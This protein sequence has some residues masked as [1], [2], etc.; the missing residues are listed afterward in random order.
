M[1]DGTV[2]LVIGLVLRVGYRAV[3]LPDLIHEYVEGRPV[4]LVQGATAHAHT[5]GRVKDRTRREL[6]VVD[7]V[8]DAQVDDIPGL[9]VGGPLLVRREGYLVGFV[10]EKQLVPPFTAFLA[11]ASTAM[12]VTQLD[13]VPTLSAVAQEAVRV[14]LPRLSEPRENLG[15][16][17]ASRDRPPC[18]VVHDRWLVDCCDGGETQGIAVKTLSAPAITVRPTHVAVARIFVVC[19]RHG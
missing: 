2:E 15:A 7:A 4:G 8:V 12:G 16:V 6:V 3:D 11:K 18:P 10:G 9:V 14:I 17:W 1:P 5:V 19:Y 13:P